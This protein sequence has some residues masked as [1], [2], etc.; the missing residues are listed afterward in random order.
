M[1]NGHTAWSAVSTG[2]VN[3]PTQSSPFPPL[4]LAHPLIHST[5]EIAGYIQKVSQSQ[6]AQPV[7]TYVSVMIATALLY[8][9]CKSYVAT[10]KHKKAIIL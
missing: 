7:A 4:P 9:W 6:P 2:S 8:F 1:G 5:C 3:L 10:I